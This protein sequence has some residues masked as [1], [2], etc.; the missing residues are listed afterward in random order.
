M[1]AGTYDYRVYRDGKL[2]LATG[3]GVRAVERAEELKREQPDAAIVISVEQHEPAIGFSEGVT[4]FIARAQNAQAR[5]RHL[6]V[7]A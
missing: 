5:S 7:V 4:A 2:S 3:V 1:N 6:Q